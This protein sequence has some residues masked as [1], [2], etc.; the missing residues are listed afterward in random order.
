[1]QRLLYFLPLLF[2][3]STLSAQYYAIDEIRE[4]RLT[5][6]QNNWEEILSTLKE[7]GKKERLIAQATLDG[8]AFDSVG[9][10]YK[11]NSSYHNTQKS[12]DRKLPFNIKLTYTDKTQTTEEGFKT[13]KLSNI[14]RD[15]SFVRE[16]LSYE[17]ARKYMPAS[18]CNFMKLYIND[19][20]W[21]LYNSTQSVDGKFLKENFG[22]NDGAFFKCDPE[23]GWKK[24]DSCPN[25]EY[26]SLLYIGADSTCY[27]GFYECKSDE[28][29]GELIKLMKAVKTMPNNLEEILAV[30]EALWMLAFNNIL[31]NLD[32]YT[33]RL[34]H[35]YYLYQNQ[36]GQFHPIIWDLNLSFGGFRFSGLGTSMSNEEMQRMS[37]F[38]HYKQKNTKRPLITNLLNNSL[39]RKVYIAHMKTMLEEN[40]VNE[41]YKKRIKE[42]QDSIEESVKADK[43]RLYPIETLRANVNSTQRA[44]NSNIIGVAELMDARTDYLKNHP[45]FK[46]PTPTIINVSHEIVDEEVT[47]SA[48]TENAEQGWLVYRYGKQDAF[49]RIKME[50]GGVYQDGDKKEIIWQMTVNKTD[51]LQYYIIAEGAKAATLSPARASFEFHDLKT[52][53]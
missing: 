1:M 10:R 37:S 22:D 52:E 33:G 16:A 9:V 30:D 25:T 4:V 28:G 36:S 21:G 27:E 44:G 31:V 13:L 29:W 20:Y 49:K 42:I 48:T 17:I 45:L 50:K 23:W 26:A 38:I 11:G 14:F 6:K 7:R 15:P 39:Y 47:V 35:N 32:S 41:D 43:K 8:V 18:Q 34:S 5:F 53:S 40:F 46:K 24:K 2:V 51:D 3:A 19:E 12:N